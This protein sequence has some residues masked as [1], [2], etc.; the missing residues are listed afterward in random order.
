MAFHSTPDRQTTKIGLLSTGKV[1]KWLE[2]W[3]SRHGLEGPNGVQTQPEGGLN[4]S[5]MEWGG[6]VWNEEIKNKWSPPDRWTKLKWM[7]LWGSGAGLQPKGSS[8]GP[9]CNLPPQDPQRSKMV[10]IRGQIRVPEGPSKV[11]PDKGPNRA[12][13][14]Q[15][16]KVGLEGLKIGQNRVKMAFSLTP[17]RQMTKL[18]F[19]NRKSGQNYQKLRVLARVLEGPNRSL[20]LPKP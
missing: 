20:H 2:N 10:K 3:R 4:G 13:F 11:L 7:A 12:H 18:T 17:D 15:G 16:Q 8:Q 5:E 14:G 6:M 9:S 1:T 19:F